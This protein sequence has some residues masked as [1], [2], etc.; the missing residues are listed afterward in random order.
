[1]E[2]N[3]IPE[4]IFALCYFTLEQFG[5]KHKTDHKYE[6]FKDT[7]MVNTNDNPLFYVGSQ[8]EQIIMAKLRNGMQ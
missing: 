6:S 4:I 3:K 7:L 1:M 8:Q 2:N 5:W